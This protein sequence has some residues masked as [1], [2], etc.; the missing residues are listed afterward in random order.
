MAGVGRSDRG[1]H[2]DG[3]DSSPRPPYFR[4]EAERKAVGVEVYELGAHALEE[5]RAM[6]E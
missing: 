1:G 3:G 4:S 6:R 2:I 5:T